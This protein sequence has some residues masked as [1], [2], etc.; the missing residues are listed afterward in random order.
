MP[1]IKAEAYGED[2][3]A[4]VYIADDGKRLTRYGGSRAW[5]NNNPGNIRHTEFARRHGAIGSAGGFA[6]FP[7]YLI[8]RN[9]ISIML[10]NEK[11]FDLSISATISRYAPRR[12]MIPIDTRR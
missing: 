5:R 11:Y 10:K 9:A 8:G 12:K 7:D 4:V 1:Y 6:L 2:S 3:A